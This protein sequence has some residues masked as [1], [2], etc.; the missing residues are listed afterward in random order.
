MCWGFLFVCLN[1]D[2]GGFIRLVRL[3]KWI[4]FTFKYVHYERV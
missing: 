2:L 4:C 3:I 1:E